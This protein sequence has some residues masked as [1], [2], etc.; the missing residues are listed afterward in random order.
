MKKILVIGGDGF[1]GSHLLG[2][3]SNQQ[4]YELVA[5]AR[6]V[7]NKG[8]LRKLDINDFPCLKSLL[9][10]I[11]P[12]YIINLAGSFSH[13]ASKDNLTNIAGPRNIFNALISL[14]LFGTKTLL[15]GSS[16]EYG[17]S[18][19]GTQLSE[20]SPLKP[21]NAYG[22]SKVAQ[23]RLATEYGQTLPIVIAR[24]FNLIGPDA[25]HA[26]FVG[27]FFAKIRKLL[28]KE[29]SNITVG[30]LSAYRDFLDIRDACSA[31]ITIIE[32]GHPGE[33]YNVAGGISHP[34]QEIVDITLERL[35]LRKD[36]ISSSRSESN[37]GVTHQL[38]SIKK[39][40]SLGWEK[41]YS[42]E[43][44]ISYILKNLHV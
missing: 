13:D 28:L 41:K 21:Q 14:K 9:A 26:L 22:E 18:E 19:I 43:D 38:A 40:R 42:L 15:I 6:Q 33:I 27:S 23:T 31:Y 24:S 2:I 7:G 11:K 16:A 29:I 39:I 17:S 8:H 4:N 12:D 37:V 32:K 10:E 1:T 44:S 5:T 25:P 30:D 34:I 36:V 3:L 35:L 20:E